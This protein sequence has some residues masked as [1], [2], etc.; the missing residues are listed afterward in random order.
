MGFF[1]R[2]KPQPRWKHPEAAVRV[3]AIDAMPDE[4]QELLLQIARE[5]TEP[6]VRRAAVAKLV[7]RECP[8][9]HR[10]HGRR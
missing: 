7:R 8:R 2:F 1:D 6:G 9:R 5:D 4:E 3:A 10:A